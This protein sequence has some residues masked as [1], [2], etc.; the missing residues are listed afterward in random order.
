MET[1]ANKV[2][3]E[4]SV[5]TTE[6]T[7]VFLVV[8]G[9]PALKIA[10]SG[11]AVVGGFEG[12][13]KTLE[14][15]F[16]PGV[17]HAN[18]LREISRANIDLIC[19]AAKCTIL[20]VISNEHRD[21]YLLS[22]SSLFIHKYHMLIKTCGTTT[23][24]CCFPVLQK[25]AEELGMEVDWIAYSRKN[26][27]FPGAQQFPHLSFEQEA[28]Y[29]DKLFDG[30]GSAYIL[31]PMNADHWFVYNVDYMEQPSIPENGRRLDIMMFDM[32]PSVAKLFSKD[33]TQSGKSDSELGQEVSDSTGIS[34]LLPGAKLDSFMFDPCGYSA[35]GLLFGSYI[36]I[37]VTPEP[38]CSYAS[39]ETNA[40]L[41]SFSSLVKN[42]L[43]VFKPKRFVMTLFA[44]EIARQDMTE[45]PF[46]NKTIDVPGHGTYK[47]RSKSGTSFE[48]D[49]T[50]EMA[51]FNLLEEGAI[52]PGRKSL[53]KKP[54][55][56]Y[57]D[58]V[59]G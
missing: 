7:S 25:F 45:D 16:K 59:D 13:E 52:S 39:F 4:S 51:N 36:T 34:S 28:S 10:D 35:N 21:A 2:T 50:F 46:A 56:K 38:E 27:T 11:D 48:E 37:H 58:V 14:I 41:K 40:N 5:T 6:E 26:F 23:L 15:D 18:G 29:L 49:Y 9:I 33:A 55:R 8:D 24:L 31:G 42:V 53:M 30:V 19:D 3:T 43:Q 57:S 32:A 1:Q 47:M 17:G 12:P 22:E 44:D 54:S 20:S